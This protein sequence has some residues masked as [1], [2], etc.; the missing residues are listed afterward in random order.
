MSGILVTRIERF[1]KNPFY[2]FLIRLIQ[3]FYFLAKMCPNG[4]FLKKGRLPFYLQHRPNQFMLAG[5][6]LFF[7]LINKKEIQGYTYKRN[8][9]AQVAYL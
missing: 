6:I 3:R 7:I 5:L 8:V 2:L 4:S 1:F 9:Y